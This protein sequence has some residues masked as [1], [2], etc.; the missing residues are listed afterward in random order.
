MNR[1][2]RKWIF[3]FW[4]LLLAV[5]ISIELSIGIPWAQEIQ[6]FDI[7]SPQ[8]KP[9]VLEIDAPSNNMD[10][11]AFFGIVQRNLKQSI[12][13][14]NSLRL[15]A[16]LP[17]ENNAT[18]PDLTFRLKLSVPED[19]PAKI[20]YRLQNLANDQVLIE[21]QVS[22]E[23]LDNLR[24]R[25]LRLSDQILK[26][27]LNLT[28]LAQTR[29]AYVQSTLDFKKN[30]MLIDFDGDDEQRLSYNLWINSLPL[31]SSDN[32][33]LLYTSFTHNE[34]KI[35]IQPTH[36]LKAQSLSF[37]QGQS[38][39]GSWAPDNQSI[40]LTLMQEGNSD[41]Y[42][43][44]LENKRLLQMTPWK[45]LETSPA[46]SPDGTRMAF[47]SDRLRHQFPQI[48][49]YDFRTRKFER[50]TVQGPYNSSPKWSPDGQWL[51]YEGRVNGTFQI[52][53]IHTTIRKP[54]QLTFGNYDSEKPDWSPNGRQLVFSSKREGNPK[55]YYM[56][57][58]GGNMVRVT[59]A[60][61][62]VSETDPSWSRP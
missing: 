32:K 40:L 44:E 22:L 20:Q 57:A 54:Q 31:W 48:F 25:A 62:F 28:G 4:R 56:R 37:E 50:L 9:V 34:S 45:S 52:F 23:S 19:A 35:H 61:D 42:L 38:L 55:L 21:S 49:L 47:V 7:D 12:F 53:K 10:A 33:S 24:Q 11:R 15:K 2:Q 60:P 17:S 29:I 6:Y 14:K 51:A 46:W 39:S 3:R 26:E 18:S 8:F 5:G 41:I 13:L 1:Q 16:Y 43:Y 27:T 36:R 59:D 30:I 58:D